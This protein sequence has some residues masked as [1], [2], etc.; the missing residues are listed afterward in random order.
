MDPDIDD[1]EEEVCVEVSGEPHVLQ[2]PAEKVKKTQ[3]DEYGAV[4]AIFV[5]I[6]N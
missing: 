4:L 2:E 6:E 3:Y 1:D 5:K